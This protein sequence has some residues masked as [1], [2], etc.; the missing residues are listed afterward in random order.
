MPLT[1]TRRL[2]YRLGGLTVALAVLHTI[3]ALLAA[4]AWLLPDVVTAQTLAHLS[5][6]WLMLALFS[7]WL[8]AGLY[9]AQ[10]RRSAARLRDEPALR[11]LVA[12]WSVAALLLPPARLLL[13]L[14]PLALLPAVAALLCVA[15][16]FRSLD[17]DSL[18]R[19]RPRPPRPEEGTARAT[20]TIALRLWAAGLLLAALLYPAAGRAALIAG[21]LPVSVALL[22]WLMPRYS[23]VSAAWCATGA[24]AQ[25]SLLTLAGGLA[26]LAPVGEVAGG[27]LWAVVLPPVM[28][29]A[30]LYRA[31]T[32]HQPVYT[33]AAHY[34]VLAGVLWLAALSV[35]GGPLLFPGIAALAGPAGLAAAQHNLILGGLLATVLAVLNQM[36]AELRGENRRVTGL[37]PF[38]LISSGMLFGGLAQAAAALVAL[39]LDGLLRLEAGRSAA[40]QLPLAALA[41]LPAALLAAG[42]VLYALGWRARRI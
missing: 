3:L 1:T 35:L 16:V 17:A 9:L 37:L 30:H 31:C 8:L 24:L 19:A 2:I 20:W 13:P 15:L 10:D 21:G 36:A 25:G 34:S 22:F 6:D 23:Q 4:V 39:Y 41:S 32:R 5:A 28:L 7:G 29:L 27:L 33:L 14:P 11:G 18:L 38:W 42:L 40:L 26:L 12:A